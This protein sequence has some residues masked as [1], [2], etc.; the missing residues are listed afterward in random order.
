MIHPSGPFPHVVSIL[1]KHDTEKLLRHK[2]TAIER[3]Y[4]TQALTSTCS[5]SDLVLLV[6][7]E[8]IERAILPRSKKPLLYM[9]VI[10]IQKPS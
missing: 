4:R 3:Y 9:Q 7:Q 10:Y 1:T 2:S 5:T 8:P 6:P